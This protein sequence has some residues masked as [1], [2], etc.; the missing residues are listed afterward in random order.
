MPK[1]RSYAELG[2]RDPKKVGLGSIALS[3]MFFSKNFCCQLD[4]SRKVFCWPERFFLVMH[5]LGL[6]TTFVVFL[7]KS[8]FAREGI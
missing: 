3:K 5:L 6:V 2:L 7:K 4:M 1:L 8:L